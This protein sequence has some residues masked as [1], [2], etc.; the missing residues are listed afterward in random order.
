MRAILAGCS[1]ETDIADS[2]TRTEVR[3]VNDQ[4]LEFLTTEPLSCFLMLILIL[5]LTNCL[6]VCTYA[7]SSL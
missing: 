3:W 6:S 5:I 4:R 7:L 2:G 1:P